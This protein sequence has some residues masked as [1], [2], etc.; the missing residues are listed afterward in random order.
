MTTVS[1]I[2]LISSEP[3]FVQV[4]SVLTASCSPTS[5][6]YSLTPVQ[7]FHLNKVPNSLHFAQPNGFASCASSWLT[8]YGDGSQIYIFSVHLS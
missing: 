5:S 4:P 6:G 2:P 3:N 1:L 7:L 8:L